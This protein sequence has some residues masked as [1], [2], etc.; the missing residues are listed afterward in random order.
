MT[1]HRPD[2]Y[3][4]NDPFAAQ[5]LRNLIAAGAIPWGHVDERSII[6]VRAG[7]LAGYRRHHFF[8]GI[9]VWALALELAGWPDSVPV[10]TGSCPCQPFSVSGRRLGFADERHLWPAWFTLIA[11]CRPGAILGEQVAAPDAGP[12]IDA[13]FDDL[14]GS[15]YTCGAVDFPSCGIGAPNIRQRL[16]WVADTNNARLEGRRLSAGSAD[17]FA[18]GAGGLACGLADTTGPRPLPGTHPGIHR[19]QESA[20]ARHGEPERLGAVGG[21]WRA[22]DWI[23][24]SDERHR[25]VEPGTR[26]LVDGAAG[27][28]GQL[29]AYGNAIN[30][31]AAAEVIAAYMD[32][33]GIVPEQAL[34]AAE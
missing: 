16:W 31:Q 21:F 29:R 15:G 12:W 13:V 8:A 2:W 33:R 18:I 23:W 14:E 22:A 26:P 34:M 10:W 11:E 27:R 1:A 25:P 7:D 30:A 6:D 24:C 3:N 32:V 4:E 17:Q 5:W 19:T 20:R 28:V 9:G